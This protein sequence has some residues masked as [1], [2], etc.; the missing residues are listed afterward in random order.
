MFNDIFQFCRTDSNFVACLKNSFQIFF[1][2]SEI[3]NIE[4]W[5]IFPA[6]ANRV[7][8]CKQMSPLTIPVNQIQN[9]KFLIYFIRMNQNRFLLIICTGK[10]KT[11]KKLLPAFVNRFGI[12]KICLIQILNGCQL[13]IPY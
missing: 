8:F 13:L 4:R 1:I 5:G 2:K 9:R 6:T 7:G 12:F 3:L 10:F 11:G